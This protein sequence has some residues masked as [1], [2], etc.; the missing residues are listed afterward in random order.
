MKVGEEGIA[1]V[2]AD[3]YLG[4]LY[5]RVFYDPQGNSLRIYFHLIM[6]FRATNVRAGN[7]V[8]PCSDIMGERALG[9]VS[10]LVLLNLPHNLTANYEPIA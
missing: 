4:N 8:R 2:Q 6:L 1:S 9:S 5:T 7:S 10:S 3:V